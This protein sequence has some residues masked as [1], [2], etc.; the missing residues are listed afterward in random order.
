VFTISD[1]SVRKFKCASGLEA[2]EL[3]VKNNYTS[4]TL[5]DNKYFDLVVEETKFQAC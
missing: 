1:E 3:E 5:S 4:F 2:I